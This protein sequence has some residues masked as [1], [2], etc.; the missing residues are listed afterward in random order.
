MPRIRLNEYWRPGGATYVRVYV[1]D[2]SADDMLHGVG[3]IC[4]NNGSAMHEHVTAG[5]DACRRLASFRPAEASNSTPDTCIMMSN[6]FPR[7]ALLGLCVH[8]M[9]ATGR[10]NSIYIQDVPASN[11]T[12]FGWC[13]SLQPY[14]ISLSHC[15]STSLQPPVR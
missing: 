3:R 8:S 12:V 11:S 13:T 7:P 2:R 14:S 9:A 4:S 1:R 10:S 15:S 6:L 5:V